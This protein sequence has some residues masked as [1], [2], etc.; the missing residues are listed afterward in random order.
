MLK[1]LWHLC[2]LVC[3]AAMTAGCVSRPAASPTVPALPR[4]E[5]P[6]L[7]LKPCRLPVL[8]ANPTQAD[9]D[10]AYMQRGEALLSCEFARR[11]AVETLMAERQLVDAD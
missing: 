4:L 9:L 1:H 10:I 3:C 6:A 2:V 7:V 8:P 11:L 5:I